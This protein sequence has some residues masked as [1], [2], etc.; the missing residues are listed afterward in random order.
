MGGPSPETHGRWP[1]GL[2]VERLRRREPPDRFEVVVSSSLGNGP[3][4]HR[5]L[6]SVFL[7]LAHPQLSPEVAASVCGA[8][9]GAMRKHEP[10]DSKDTGEV[11]N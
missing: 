2:R 4:S 8:G 10:P 7:K 11:P 6:D 1:P 3:I 5:A 9:R